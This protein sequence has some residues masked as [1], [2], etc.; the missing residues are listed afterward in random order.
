M[1]DPSP[2]A[3]QRLHPTVL[4]HLVNTLGW[5][6][7]RPAQ[8]A[9]VAPLLA[10]DDL[11]MVAP[12]AG[13][14]TKAAMLPLLS[15]MAEQDWT[16]T[17]VLYLCPLKALLNNLLPRLERYADWLGR[18]A[19]IWHGDTTAGHRRKTQREQPDILLTTPESLE[20]MLVSANTTTSPLAGGV[21]RRTQH[22]RR[23]LLAG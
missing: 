4:H 10:G 16:G 18:R 12:T 21:A 20:A 22:E 17:S 9:A 8:Q 14:K 2:D 6:G 13:G 1:T 15:R 5:S 19:A 23:A 7:L 3:A 11:V